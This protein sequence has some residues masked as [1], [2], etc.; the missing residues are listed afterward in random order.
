[1][2]H[3]FNS[4]P[5]A[6]YEKFLLAAVG[7]NG[8]GEKLSVLSALARADLDPLSEAASLAFLPRDTA[9]QRLLQIIERSPDISPDQATLDN[10]LRLAALLPTGG[11]HPELTAVAFAPGKNVRLLAWAF[12]FLIVV[13]ISLVLQWVHGQH[14]AADNAAASSMPHFT[15][16]PTDRMKNER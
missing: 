11:I 4:A 2:V 6:A 15:S 1:M 13:V 5:R 12:T 3:A 14:V 9:A 7:E 16:S 8:K 10:A